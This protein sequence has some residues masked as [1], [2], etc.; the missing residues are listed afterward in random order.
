MD[1]AT[2]RTPSKAHESRRLETRPKTLANRRC[3]HRRLRAGRLTRRAMRAGVLAV[4]GLLL[5]TIL[6]TP[7]QAGPSDPRELTWDKPGV[8][9]RGGG[10]LDTSQVDWLYSQ[11]FRAIA[12]F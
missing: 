7:A 1:G 11:G 4:V 10:G 6:P 5:F 12:N 8:L 9:A 2:E 3:G